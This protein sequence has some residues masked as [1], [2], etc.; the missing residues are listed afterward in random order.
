MVSRLICTC[1]H[2]NK[3]MDAHYICIQKH[4]HVLWISEFHLF[5][6]NCYSSPKIKIK[7]CQ[8][9]HSSSSQQGKSI[10]KC[11]SSYILIMSAFHSGVLYF[12]LKV[13]RG[14]ALTYAHFHRPLPLMVLVVATLLTF[15]YCEVLGKWRDPAGELQA[16]ILTRSA[17][18]IYMSF[19]DADSLDA[20]W[21]CS[22]RLSYHCLFSKHKRRVEKAPWQ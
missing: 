9:P 3:H 5:L 19:S 16:T 18:F 21:A 15:P 17:L 10:T 12:P 13:F 8:Y 1:S 14:N 22:Q 6:S 2:I 11:F 4:T 20:R 7:G